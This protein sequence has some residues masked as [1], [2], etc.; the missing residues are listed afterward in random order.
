MGEDDGCGVVVEA[1]FDH[2]PR[3]D[4][5]TVDGT[6][7]QFFD[8]DNMMLIIEKDTAKDFVLVKSEL[9]DQVAPGGCGAG[10]GIGVLG[11]L[12]QLALGQFLEGGQAGHSSR[13]QP[14]L[15]AEL[16]SL[17]SQQATDAPEFVEQVSGQ[18]QSALALDAGLDN[19]SQ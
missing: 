10:E 17:H 1:A 16:G 7:E 14:G 15:G 3:I 18:V 11:L 12:Q 19:D 13:A 8:F 9:A 4:G 6:A 2:F 5:G